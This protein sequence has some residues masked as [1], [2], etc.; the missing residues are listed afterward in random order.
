MF[1]KTETALGPVERAI[2]TMQRLSLEFVRPDMILARDVY[3]QDGAIMIAAD[4]KLTDRLIER[5]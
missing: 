1:P 4:A 3:D 5:L 2:K